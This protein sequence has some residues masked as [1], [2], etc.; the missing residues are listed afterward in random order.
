MKQDP[1]SANL[2]D[3]KALLAKSFDGA[4][5]DDVPPLPESLRDRIS[6]QYGR[7][8]SPAPQAHSPGFFAWLTSLFA[9]PAFAGVAAA[10]V[11]V[12]TATV[13]L[14][15]PGNDGTYRGDPGAAGPAVTLVLFQV[16]DAATQSIRSADL[17][18]EKAV[19]V[20]TTIA[21]LDAIA[22]PRIVIDGSTG[23]IQAFAEGSDTPIEAPLPT[24]PQELADTVADLLGKIR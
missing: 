18:D 22:P 19:R 23:T 16:D 17:F 5:G 7:S 14:N 6:D 4:E 24:A 13:L 9:Q 2:D 8:S 10:L 15:K 21:E 1:N 20:A 12:I 3:L 11:L